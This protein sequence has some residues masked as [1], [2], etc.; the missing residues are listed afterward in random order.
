M[1]HSIL[2]IDDSPSIRENI[3]A[4]LKREGL[5]DEYFEAPNGAQGFKLLVEKGADVVLCDL[6]MPELDGFKFLELKRAKPELAGIPVIMLTAEGESNK[7]VKGLEIG[8]S[9]YIV[10][11]FHE[12]E[13]LARVRVHLHIKT[14]QDELKGA[15]TRL[16]QLSITDSLTGIY[17]RRYFMENLEKEFIRC[18]RYGGMFSLVL[19]DIDHFKNINDTYGHILGDHALKDVCAVASK[20]L[21][22]SDVLARF[23]GEEFVLLLPNTD[24]GGAAAIAERIRGL[25]EKHTVTWGKD[26]V[27][28]TLSAGVS[29]FPHKDAQSP[30]SLMKLADKALYSA[31]SDGRNKV[32]VFK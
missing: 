29:T 24:T 9:D 21:R 32:A 17:N 25:I 4:T 5:F 28:L 3:K 14:L 12:G 31:K 2:I 7:K 23:G 16:K 1:K 6:M 13:L 8:A 10:K 22:S 11:P 30:D 26:S 15:N 27:K 20:S 18:E 19:M